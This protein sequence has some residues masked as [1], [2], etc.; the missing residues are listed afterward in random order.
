I[1]VRH[2]AAA[3]HMAQAHAEL[4]G[5]LAVA[6]VTAGPGVTNAITGMASAQT[7]GVPVLVI[8]GARPQHQEYLAA[9]QDLPHLDIVRPITQHARTVRNGRQT[10]RELD[11][12]VSCAYGDY[13]S[14]GCAYIEFPI[15]VLRE[16]V[17]PSYARFGSS[18]LCGACETEPVQDAIAIAQE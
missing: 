4:T 10:L 3:V 9:F 12:A 8:G 5:R 15:D 17:P 6:T 2:E 14:A 13:G 1:D 18:R 7:S 11:T 16:I